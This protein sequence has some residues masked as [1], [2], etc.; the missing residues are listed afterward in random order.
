MNK[1]YALT[2]LTTV[3]TVNLLD[4]GLMGLLL[5]PIK[6]DFHLSDTQL[7]FLTGIAYALFFALLGIPMGRWAD[8]GNRVT[9]ISLVLTLWG[10]TNM[11]FMFVGT[12]A[13]LLFLRI[14]AAAGDVGVKPLTYSLLGDYFPQQAERTRAM[15]IWYLAAPLSA[16]ISFTSAGWLNERFG[17]RTAFFIVGLLG[18]PLALLVKLTL[19]EPRAQGALAA[20]NRPAPAVLS[21][22]ALLWRQPSCRHLI[23]GIVLTYFVS[24]GA[25]AWQAAFM[26]RS[27][28]MGTA[29]LGIWMGIAGGLASIVSSL[30]GRYIVDRWFVHSERSQMRFVAACLASGGPLLLILLLTPVK[31]VALVAFLFLNI[32][33]GLCGA[34][35][36]AMLQ[37]LVPDDMRAT[38]LMVVLMLA[39]LIGL[40]MGPLLV[41][42]LSDLLTPSFGVDGLRYAMV[43]MS[44]GWL[45]VAYHYL[46]VSST[47]EADLQRAGA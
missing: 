10:L 14:L 1:R 44:I 43:T 25:M 20:E 28:A 12:F 46:H 17:W 2:M 22:L 38:V 29:E 31:E 8:R 13:Q 3:F 18:L 41:G 9:L 16:I 11:A 7:G 37:R 34:P 30:A 19:P 40:G 32:A 35:P 6:A 24:I 23:L 4:R 47:V 39:N 5:Q 21:T 26:M 36:Y 33:A 27:H 45:W 15:Y 42:R